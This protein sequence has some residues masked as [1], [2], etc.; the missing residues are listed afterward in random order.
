MQT[1][2]IH[3]SIPLALLVAVRFLDGL[4]SS[5]ADRYGDEIAS[6]RLGTNP[7]VTA[8]IDRYRKLERKQ[9]YVHCND[10]VQLFGLVN[11]RS[12]A[13]LAFGHAG[14]WAARRATSRISLPLRV[15]QRAVPGPFRFGVGFAVT[16]RLADKVFAIRMERSEGGVVAVQCRQSHEGTPQGETCEFYGAVLAELMRCLT[17]FDGAMLHEA[18]RARGDDECKWQTGTDLER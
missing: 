4:V 18:C 16:R 17:D 1:D 15:L 6:K 7:T 8:Q 12:D 2:R 11:R 5:G 10:V 13:A 14:R 9:A 3:P